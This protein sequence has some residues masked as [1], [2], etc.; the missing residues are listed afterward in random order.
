[1]SL[2]KQL[3][4]KAGKVDTRPRTTRTLSS[5]RWCHLRYVNIDRRRVREGHVQA[6]LPRVVNAVHPRC[7]VKC[8]SSALAVHQRLTLGGAGGRGVRD[9]LC[10][11]R[12][13]DAVV[14]CHCGQRGRLPDA[15]GVSQLLPVGLAITI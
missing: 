12:V 7:L 15:A 10:V 3:Q 4:C 5:P 6:L 13:G 2:E 9:I 8:S 14:C 11:A 1:M